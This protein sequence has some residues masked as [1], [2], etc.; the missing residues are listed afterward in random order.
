MGHGLDVYIRNGNGNAVAGV[1]VE[2]AVDAF[3]CGGSL[4]KSTD[5]EGRAHFETADW[6]D[7][8]HVF[9]YVGHQWFGPFQFPE[10]IY[11]IQLQ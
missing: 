8:D 5:D 1:R 2:V 10:G 4:Y 7:D 9:P 11:S 3:V 6:I